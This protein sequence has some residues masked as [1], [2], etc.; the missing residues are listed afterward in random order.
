MVYRVGRAG[1][2]LS[3]STIPV[4]RI[5]DFRHILIRDFPVAAAGDPATRSISPACRIKGY[6][7]ASLSRTTNFLPS[8]SRQSIR[9][10]W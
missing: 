6:R 1:I 2:R 3:R 8:K 4:T 10:I 9:T 5:M 7:K